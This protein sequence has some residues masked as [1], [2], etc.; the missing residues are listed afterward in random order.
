MYTLTTTISF[1]VAI[2]VMTAIGSYDNLNNVG[3]LLYNGAMILLELGFLMFYMRKEKVKSIFDELVAEIQR[4]RETLLE[5]IDAAAHLIIH[6]EEN[7]DD[8]MCPDDDDPM[9]QNTNGGGKERAT[10][11]HLQGKPISNQGNSNYHHIAFTN[12][13]SEKDNNYPPL[14]TSF[15]L[16]TNP[17]K[18]LQPFPQN[19]SQKTPPTGDMAALQHAYR[20]AKNAANV[21]TNAPWGGIASPRGAG[22]PFGAL[23]KFDRNNYECESSLT[24]RS[25]GA[26]PLVYRLQMMNPFGNGVNNR[27]QKGSSHVVVDMA[28][29]NSTINTTIP[30]HLSSP[31]PPIAGNNTNNS[32]IY[33]N[34]KIEEVDENEEEGSSL[35]E[36][37]Q[38]LTQITEGFVFSPT[39]NIDSVSSPAI[40]Q[41]LTYVGGQNLSDHLSSSSLQSI[42]KDQEVEKDI[43]GT[44]V[45]LQSQ[46]QSQSLQPQSQLPFQSL[47]QPQQHCEIIDSQPTS[48]QINHPSAADSVSFL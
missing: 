5:R 43:G 23:H 48:P 19:M 10:G 41:T 2:I 18:S 27:K 4:E 17:Q 16:A 1:L 13:N 12:G 35:S 6:N 24:S 38:Q 26:S 37:L 15:P 40:T 7:V 44:I 32:M 39:I 8:Q 29:G 34:H 30:S 42:P 46:L 25:A 31:P 11:G 22:S 14:P 9:V 20:Q 33:G 36:A 3:L 21:D 45:T 28:K 47:P